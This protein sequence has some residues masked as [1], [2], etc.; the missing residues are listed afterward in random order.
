VKYS[1]D[2]SAFIEGVR[3]YPL[4]VFPTVWEYLDKLVRH[5]HLKA[6]DEVKREL[7]PHGDDVFD[8]VKRRKKLLIAL[9]TSIQRR[10]VRIQRQ[11]PS[12]VKIDKTRPDADPFVIALAQEHGLAVVTYESTK[13][14]KPRIPDVCETLGIPC[15]ALVEV[16]RR[17]GWKL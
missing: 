14:S 7:E 10:V 2:T 12:L 8:W 1:F 4:E 3:H 17:E 9:D 11:F 16:F 5:D 6:I 13:P 15:I